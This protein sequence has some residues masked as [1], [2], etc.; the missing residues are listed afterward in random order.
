MPVP[1]FAVPTLFISIMLSISVAAQTVAP[2]G[3]KVLRPGP[4][5]PTGPD[6]FQLTGSFTVSKGTVAQPLEERSFG[7]GGACI[8]ADLAAVGAP[9]LSC[10]N[11]SQC[12]EAFAEFQDANVGNPNYDAASFSGSSGQCIA[13]RCWYRPSRA[14]CTRVV[15][16]NSWELG[17]HKFGP[18]DLHHVSKLFGD[19]SQINWLVVTCSN[20][21][22]TNGVDDTACATGQGLYNPSSEASRQN[23]TDW[24]SLIRYPAGG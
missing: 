9:E 14:L 13:N 22:Q 19:D 5:I 1:R 8:Y 17:N 16:P 4:V 10:S 2:P 18:F 15:P 3:F 12:T 21:A 7:S 20:H 11:N 6:N 24:E 23:A